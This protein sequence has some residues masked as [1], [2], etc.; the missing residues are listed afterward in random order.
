MEQYI[1]LIY[2]VETLIGIKFITFILSDFSKNAET[3]RFA[4]GFCHFLG[5]SSF[6]QGGTKK[7]TTSTSSISV[8]IGNRPIK[9]YISELVGVSSIQKCN[10]I[11]G[12][13]FKIIALAKRGWRQDVLKDIVKH[14][15]HANVSRQTSKER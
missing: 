12:I 10:H 1:K 13:P 7:S 6:L 15:K 11:R 2:K 3:G 9:P 14:P 8:G 5:V 4:F